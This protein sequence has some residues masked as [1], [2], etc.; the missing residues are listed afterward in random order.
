MDALS[1]NE[2]RADSPTFRAENAGFSPEADVH[3]S[4]PSLAAASINDLGCLYDALVAAS[5]AI[6]AIRN[7]PRCRVDGLAGDVLD[8]MCDQLGSLADDAAAAMRESRPQTV[9]DRD[10]RMR[11]LFENE[12]RI[13]GGIRHMLDLAK[14]L[15][16]EPA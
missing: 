6:L 4:L 9:W 15:Q 14:Q 1:Y 3:V 5:E 13:G 16:S 10:A 7:Q 12:V 11:L 8:E 2:P